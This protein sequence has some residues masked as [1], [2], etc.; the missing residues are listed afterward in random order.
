MTQENMTI[1]TDNDDVNI[2]ELLEQLKSGWRW[3]AGGC[4]IGLLGAMGFLM[5][6]PSKYEAVA[7]LQPAAIGMSVSTTTAVE[8]IAQTTERLKLVKFYDNDVVTACQAG[9]AKDLADGV[10]VSVIKGNDLISL[11]YRANSVAQ[12]E[13]CMSKIVDHLIK[14]QVNI[15]TPMLK[16]LEDQLASTEQEINDAK[17]FLMQNEKTLS[18]AQTG[19]VLLILKREELI[20][21][22]KLYREQ[23]IKLTEPLTKP[24]KLLGPIYTSER[25]VSPRKRETVVAGLIAGLFLGLL[26]LFIYR[27][28]RRYKSVSH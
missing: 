9:S 21:L 25:P 14:S 1:E 27:S 13:A 6:T 2:W 12:T 10:K 8:P 3:L 22:Q 23:R 4:A 19:A 26:A 28:R 15:S 11:S 20:K 17:S 5:L 18:S 24:M 7:V 16:E